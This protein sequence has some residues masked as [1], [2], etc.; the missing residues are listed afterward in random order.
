MVEEYTFGGSVGQALRAH[1]PIVLLGIC[2]LRPPP[3]PGSVDTARAGVLRPQSNQ[4]KAK[5]EKD[6]MFFHGKGDSSLGYKQSEHHLS[7]G[8]NRQWK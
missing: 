1:L 4:A 8:S 3:L 6:K 5:N 7:E 2:G